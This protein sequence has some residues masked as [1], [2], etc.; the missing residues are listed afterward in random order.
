MRFVLALFVLATVVFGGCSGSNTNTNTNSNAN[1]N[2]PAAL[3]DVQPLKPQTAVDQ[4]FKPCNPYYP[5][6]P[7]S[8][9][10]YRLNFSSGLFADVNIV[11]DSAQEGGR[12]TFVETTQIVDTGGGLEKL[13]RT[14]RKYVCDSERIQIIYEKGNNRAGELAN[15]FGSKFKNI[16]VLMVEPASLKRKGSVWSYSFYQFFQVSGQPAIE[17]PDPVTVNFEVLG[18][19]EVT[20]PAGKFNAVKI[21]RTVKDKKGYDFFAKGIG[22]VKRVGPDGT[23]LELRE[24]SGVKPQE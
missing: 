21:S 18:E 7:G 24:Y 17:P 4:S 12:Q 22:L 19:E 5:L 3:P 16:P 8:E 6:L 14:V 20:T 13:E 10:K 9:V 1:A 2:Q 23:T 11:V 15:E